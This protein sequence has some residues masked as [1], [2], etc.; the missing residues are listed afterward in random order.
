MSQDSPSSTWAAGRVLLKGYL[1]PGLSDAP[2]TP[3]TP[4]GSLG[5]GLPALLISTDI[6]ALLRESGRPT[7]A[8]G[9]PSSPSSH[10]TSWEA[11]SQ[12]ADGPDSVLLCHADVRRELEALLSGTP[13]LCQCSPT[14]R[15]RPK[16]GSSSWAGRAGGE[17]A[18]PVVDSS[19]VPWQ[20][21]TR[22]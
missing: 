13:E 6:E 11:C 20:M 2:M 14:A 21:R 7:P 3:L 16:C 8:V 5:D 10:A 4:G 17:S 15:Y 18:T 19:A 22:P 12:K 1:R 9:S